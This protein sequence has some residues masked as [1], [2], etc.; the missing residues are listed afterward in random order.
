MKKA[1]VLITIVLIMGVAF[2]GCNTERPRPPAYDIP[3]IVMDYSIQE[4]SPNET[5]IFIR[6]IEDVMYDRLFLEVNNETIEKINAFSI[7]YNTNLTQF[8]LNV[9][10]FRQETRYN[11][12]ATVET[13]ENDEVIYRFNIKYFDGREDNIRPGNLPF[14]RSLNKIEE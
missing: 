14:V 5:V 9:D 3:K 13:F 7:E 4:A 8:D 12:N 6:G 11:F 10:V 1:L 2:V